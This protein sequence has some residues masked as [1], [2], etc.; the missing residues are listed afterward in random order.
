M[1]F[2]LTSIWLFG[3]TWL[4]Y[5]IGENFLPEYTNLVTFGFFILALVL[6]FL[7]R[8]FGDIVDGVGDILD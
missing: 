6:R 4:G 5:F 7:P 8:I 3:M 1:N 2:L